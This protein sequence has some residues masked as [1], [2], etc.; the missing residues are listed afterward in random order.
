[1]AYL[2]DDKGNDSLLRLLA[3]LGFI[4]GGSMIASGAT[5]LFMQIP[6][7][8]ILVVSGTTLAAGGEVLKAIQKKFEQVKA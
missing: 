1:M 7:M 2:K 6:K 4:L 3:L 8:E 5:G